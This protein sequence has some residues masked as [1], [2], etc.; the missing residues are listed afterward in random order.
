MLKKRDKKGG[1][2]YESVLVILHSISFL[3]TLLESTKM[4]NLISKVKPSEIRQLI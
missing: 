3:V 4:S 2:F 1:L